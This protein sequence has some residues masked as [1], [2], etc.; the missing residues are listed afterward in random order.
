MVFENNF[1]SV[2]TWKTGMFHLTIIF[3]TICTI[4]TF[5]LDIYYGFCWEQAIAKWPA[6]IEFKQ[7]EF[8]ILH[9]FI[10]FGLKDQLHMK[11]FFFSLF[12]FGLLLFLLLQYEYNPSFLIAPPENFSSPVTAVSHVKLLQVPVS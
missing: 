7:F 10:W 12:F 1:N 5:I 9:C 2:I 11:Y 4:N 3:I 6:F 8:I